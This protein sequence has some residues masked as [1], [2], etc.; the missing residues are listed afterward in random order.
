MKPKW[1]KPQ[2]V[3]VLCWC[4]GTTFQLLFLQHK[5]KLYSP[6]MSPLIISLLQGDLDIV[7]SLGGQVV[8]IWRSQAR[9]SVVQP[10]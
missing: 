1:R 2:T 10:G 9:A 3:K 8:K 5:M 6:K 4:L 7:A